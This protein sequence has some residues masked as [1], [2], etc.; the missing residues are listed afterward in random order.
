MPEEPIAKAA[1]NGIGGFTHWWNHGPVNTPLKIALLV[2]VAALLA[3]FHGPVLMVSG[4]VLGSVYFVYLGIRLLVHGTGNDPAAIPVTPPA[5]SPNSL[6]RSPDW[7]A[8]SWEQHGRLILCEKTAG[9]HIGELSGSMLSAAVIAGILTVMMAVI[10]SDSL[11]K[12]ANPLAGPI[13]L[14]LMTTV[15]SWLVLG[16]GKWCERTSGEIVK[17]R[18]GMLVLG[19]A[20]GAI[21]YLTSQ[22]LMVDFGGPGRGT[23]TS[24]FARELLESNGAPRLAAFLA[25][26]GALFLTIGWWKQC[27]PLRSS[28]LRIGPIL[29]TMLAAWLW[30]LV[31]SFPQPWGF[32]LVA[33]ISIAAQLSAP[34]L[35]PA[36]R[37]AAIARRNHVS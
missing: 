3:I 18:F 27:D 33:A 28:R 31:M 26:F 17:R 34:W 12:S 14:W 25:Y 21:A 37:T 19:I 15:G 10:G 2:A 9:D 29:L 4:V 7:H 13:W 23:P 22:F 30:W 5:T 36:Q 6:P 8:I 11:N 20:F 35:S 32:M 24:P 16:A 1:R